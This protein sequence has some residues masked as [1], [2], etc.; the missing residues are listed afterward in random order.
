MYEV[1]ATGRQYEPIYAELH[2][3][4]T[5]LPHTLTYERADLLAKGFRILP[6]QAAENFPPF[7]DEGARRRLRLGRASCRRVLAI[8]RLWLDRI[9]WLSESMHSC[10]LTQLVSIYSALFL[11]RDKCL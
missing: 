4:T 3:A 9:R 7:A 2:E 5:C 8:I 10:F 1:V 6:H 11:L